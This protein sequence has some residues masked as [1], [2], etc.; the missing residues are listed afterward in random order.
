MGLAAP[1]DLKAK[2]LVQALWRKSVT[3][4]QDL[5]DEFK[6]QW[7][8]IQ[9]TWNM[10]EKISVPRVITYRKQ[11][12]AWELHTFVDA[13]ERSYAAVIYLRSKTKDGYRMD[14]IFSKNRLSPM[15]GR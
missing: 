3:W 15:K 7:K 9:R 1:A 2:L 8:Q 10:V 4:D 11:G 12:R 5:P 13:S 14:L 6:D